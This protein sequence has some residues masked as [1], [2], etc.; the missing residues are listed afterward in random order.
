MGRICRPVLPKAAASGLHA[1]QLVLQLHCCWCRQRLNSLTCVLY[2]FL[3]PAGLDSKNLVGNVTVTC[4]GTFA[5]GAQPVITLIVKVNKQGCSYQVAATKQATF[6]NLLCCTSG[7]SYAAMTDVSGTRK[8]CFKASDSTCSGTRNNW[9]FYIK[10]TYVG[11]IS[12]QLVSGA[13]N[14]ECTQGT[15]VGSAILTCAS[16]P[17]N[18]KPVSLTFQVTNNQKSAL[19]GGQ[20][21]YV[22]CTPVTSCG[23]SA[24]G[25]VSKTDTC[26][27]TGAIAS[28]GGSFPTNTTSS[29]MNG[30][31]TQTFTVDASASTCSSCSDV[32][33]VVHQSGN[34]VSTCA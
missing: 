10:T 21:Y 8:T 14:G 23:P 5:G 1:V 27:L 7:T 24:F 13:G 6:A 9:G 26:K 15:V 11:P 4:T 20:H 28:C 17:S 19:L 30:M 31:T 22:S 16:N 18:R 33:W 29:T 3:H 34:Y 32:Y 12:T 25:A 2:S